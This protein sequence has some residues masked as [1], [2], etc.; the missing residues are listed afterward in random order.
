MQCII[1]YSNLV[2]M[3]DK[4]TPITS[5][6][7]REMSAVQNAVIINNTCNELCY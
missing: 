5:Q 6:F 2:A 7:R 1:I 3:Y 4:L